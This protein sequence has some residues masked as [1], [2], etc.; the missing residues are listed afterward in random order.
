MDIIIY[1]RKGS[2]YYAYDDEAEWETIARYSNFTGG[3]KLTIPPVSCPVNSPVA[4]Y[5]AIVNTFGESWP[6]LGRYVLCVLLEP[7]AA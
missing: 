3:G 2:H 7:L 5:V 6:L 4:F 1:S